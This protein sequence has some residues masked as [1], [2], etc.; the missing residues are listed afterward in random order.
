MKVLVTGGAGFIGSYLVH[1]LKSFG[2]NVDVI[3][4]E[5]PKVL[6]DGVG[7]FKT[8]VRDP[9]DLMDAM[10]DAEAVVHLAATSGIQQCNEDL[11]DSFSNNVMAT[12]MILDR[13]GKHRRLIYASSCAVYGNNRNIWGKN[14]ERCKTSPVSWYGVQKRM[15]EQLCRKYFEYH[16][17]PSVVLRFF[18]VYGPGQNEQSPYCGVVTK[19][20]NLIKAGKPVDIY[21][22]GKQRRDYV[23]VGDVAEAI[24]CALEIPIENC[25][26]QPINIGSGKATDVNKIFKLLTKLNV[27]TLDLKYMKKHLEPR[28]YD[29]KVAL[30]DIRMAKKILGW[31]PRYNIL[32]GLSS[33]I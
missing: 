18:N 32:D 7:Y 29:M 25:N 6:V 1:S 10:K 17:F 11:T 31:S 12:Q 22:N 19:F 13:M 26:A 2:Y 15:S 4:R 3:D 9:L 5:S 20:N 24:R 14:Q 33:L 27:V 8:D 28:S 30:A 16:G 23:Y 21:G